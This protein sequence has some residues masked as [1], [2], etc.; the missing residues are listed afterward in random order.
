MRGKGRGVVVPFVSIFLLGA[1]HRVDL[2]PA[3]IQEFIEFKDSAEVRLCTYYAK[4]LDSR[5]MGRQVRPMGRNPPTNWAPV[6]TFRARLPTNW[7]AHYPPTYTVDCRR[8]S[9]LCA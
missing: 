4:H 3:Q 5:P 8:E 6:P 1:D 2:S 9:G 7:A